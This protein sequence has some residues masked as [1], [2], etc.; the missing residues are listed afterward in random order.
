MRSRPI[1]Y[2]FPMCPI[3]ISPKSCHVLPCFA[4]FAG[5]EGKAVDLEGFRRI[6]GQADYDGSWSR[7]E[8]GEVGPRSSCDFQV[9]GR[10]PKG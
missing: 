6:L 3:Q 10:S 8:V 9:S 7:Q 5:G 2:G 4:P 1:C